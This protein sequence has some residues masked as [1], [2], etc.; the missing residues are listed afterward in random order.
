MVPIGSAI[1]DALKVAGPRSA[2][3][4]ARHLG[5]RKADVLVACRTLAAAS[6]IRRLG[7]RWVLR[8][9]ARCAGVN[10]AG[11]QCARM[12]A[13]GNAFCAHHEPDPRTPLPPPKPPAAKPLIVEPTTLP[14]APATVASPTLR[15]EQ[16]PAAPEPLDEA[17]ELFVRGHRVTEADVIDALAMLGDEEVQAYREGRLPKA[18]AYDIARDRLRTIARMT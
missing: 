15:H 16:A 3:A 9:P 6:Q 13:P 7:K 8:L 4:L 17:P 2:S 10:K 18:K 12:A 14:Q 11:S 5:L 1:V